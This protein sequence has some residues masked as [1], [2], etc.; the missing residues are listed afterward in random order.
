MGHPH[1]ILTRLTVFTM[2]IA[3]L[4]SGCKATPVPEAATVPPETAATAP[5][6][7]SATEAPAE[8]PTEPEQ[9]LPSGPP[10]YEG[11]I[12]V[13][14]YPYLPD[15]DLFYTLLAEQWAAIAPDIKLEFVYWDCYSDPSPDNDPTGIDL[16]MYDA[17]F[18]TYL[19][20]NGFIQP[21][22]LEDVYH[23][24][25]FLPFTLEGGYQD[26]QLYGIPY[27]A[28]SFFLIHDPDD[29]ELAQVDT[30]SELA[31]VVSG[32]MDGDRNEGLMVEYYSDLPYFYLDALMDFSGEY[33]TYDNPP[34]LENLNSQV[35]EV[36]YSLSS[37]VMDVP[38]EYRGYSSF[39]QSAAFNDGYGS[40]YCGF[41]E[42]MAFMEDKIDEIMR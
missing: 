42:S 4:F 3:L 18:T 31:A 30:F 34:D 23:S 19:V 16:I 12:T 9:T 33:T 36:L 32:K 6:E 28:C 1:R 13:A 25:G 17:I 29:K 7:T 26:G 35:M 11:T 27:L 22:Q 15:L 41:S 24:E 2:I 40:A 37:V 39:K 14:A 38:S 10:D 5:A 21:I 8:A 20:E